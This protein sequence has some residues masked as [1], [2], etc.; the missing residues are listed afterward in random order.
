MFNKRLP[1]YVVTQC[2]VCASLLGKRSVS[3]IFMAHCTECQTTFTWKPWSEKPLASLDRELPKK[4]G[5][6]RCGQ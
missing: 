3:E 6:G 2:P 1:Q 4:C 5:C